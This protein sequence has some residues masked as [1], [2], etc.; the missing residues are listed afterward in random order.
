MSRKSQQKKKVKRQK[1][2]APK[3]KPVS[4][5]QTIRIAAHS[6]DADEIG[7][8]F[9]HQA[10]GGKQQGLDKETHLQRIQ[11]AILQRWPG[12]TGPEICRLMSHARCAADRIYGA[13]QVNVIG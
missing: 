9:F 11:Q 7:A 6:Y 1:R 8:W 4:A 3:Q 12:A 10:V 2:V 5:P 13:K